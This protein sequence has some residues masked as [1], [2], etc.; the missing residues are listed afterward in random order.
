MAVPNGATAG[1]GPTSVHISK[2]LNRQAL[3]TGADYLQS[4]FHHFPGMGGS[5]MNPLST[6]G[7]AP[8]LESPLKEQGMNKLP[9]PLLRAAFIVLIFALSGRG[10]GATP[11]IIA[12]DDASFPLK[13]S[14]PF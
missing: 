2:P 14:P 8:T 1:F 5:R 6:C 9:A 10:Q 4:Y 13:V 3:H 7:T 12:N 11:Y